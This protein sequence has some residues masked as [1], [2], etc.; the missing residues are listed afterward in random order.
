MI[1]VYLDSCVII[2]LIEGDVV[3]QQSI[4][5]KLVGRSIFGS[6]LACLEARITPI[7][8]NDKN[9]LHKLDR[10]FATCKMPEL[11]RAVFE[12]AIDIRV[13]SKLK[14]PD[15]IHLAVAIL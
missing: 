6:E 13:K 15:A 14:T 8:K 4:R 10:F 7:R 1:K 9:S 5:Q 2:S 11:D 12:Q 3:Q